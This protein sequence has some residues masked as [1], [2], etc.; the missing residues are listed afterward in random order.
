M[1][2][3]IGTLALVALWFPA[4]VAT[5]FL[6]SRMLGVRRSWVAVLMSGV[7]GWSA[8]FVVSLGIAGELDDPRLVRNTLVLSFVFT[9]AA[10]VGLDLLAKPGTLAQG[11]AAGLFVLPRPGRYLSDRID[12]VRRTRQIVQIAHHNGFGPQL[13]GRLRRHDDA[14]ARDPAPVRARRTL[15]QCGGMFV[16]LGQIASTRTDLLPPDFI[17]ELAKLQSDVAPDDPESMRRLIERELGASVEDVFA[18]FDWEPIGAASIAQVYKATL[19]TGEPVVVKAQ[20]PGVADVVHRDTQVLLRVAGMIDRDTPQ[21]AEYRVGDLAREFADGAAAELDFRGEAQNAIA[22]GR[23]MAGQ[24]GVRVPVVYEELSTSRLL[25]QE[26]FEGPSVSDHAAL[27][28]RDLDRRALARTLLRAAL[29]QMMTDGCFHADLHPGNVLVLDDGSLGLIDFGACGRLDPLQ[30]ASL[31]QML[32]ATALRDPAMLRQAVDDAC[33]VGSSAGEE[34][35][36]RALARFLAR[37]VQPGQA[38]SATA[39]ADLMQLLGS[40][41]IDVPVEFTT[42]GRALVVLDGTLITLDPGFNFSQEAREVASEWVT[43]SQG[44]AIPDLDALARQEL[45]AQ[46]PT[47]RVLPKRAD[48]VLRLAEKGELLTRTS[49]FSRDDDVRFVAKMVNRVVLAFAG[50]VLGIVSAVL[51]STSNGPAFADQVTLLNFF[52]YLGLFG[53]VVLLLRVTAAIVR[54]GLN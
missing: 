7:V 27:A 14:L 38:V 20:R 22:I 25:V 18:E 45:L 40:F 3:T 37:H 13:T 16:K 35:L 51:L 17:E 53:S 26:R 28:G 43:A 1:A 31:R 5:A 15:E 29:K 48:R 42:F 11:D 6:A 49:L 23:N 46:L 47:L 8:G 12:V 39:V 54:E 50:G 41:G 52:G 4:A 19:R 32:I 36:E 30:Q 34:A 2:G 24:P 44:G 33:D 10:A 21:G 9:M